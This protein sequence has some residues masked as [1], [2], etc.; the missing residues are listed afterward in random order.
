M[1]I[2]NYNINPY[3]NNNLDHH[4][5]NNLNHNINHNPDHLLKNNIVKRLKILG[6]IYY[7]MSIQYNN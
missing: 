5:K 2:R 3:L 7:L 4:L 6:V 1:K